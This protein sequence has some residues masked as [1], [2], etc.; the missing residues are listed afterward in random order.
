ML[1]LSSQIVPQPQALH[2]HLVV[3]KRLHDV[4]PRLPLSYL[5]MIWGSTDSLDPTEIEQR[6]ETLTT[7]CNNML[8]MLESALLMLQV[9]L[10]SQGSP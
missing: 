7:Y 1:N 4:I 6:K 9:L 3:A 8:K 5:E 10:K 2:K